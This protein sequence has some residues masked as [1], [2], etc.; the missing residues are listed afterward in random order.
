MQ[1][2]I[3]RY[4]CGSGGKQENWGSAGEFAFP[5]AEASGSQ[6]WGGIRKLRRLR[7]FVHPLCPPSDCGFVLFHGHVLLI[8][9][10]PQ[11]PHAAPNLHSRI[12]LLAG[13]FASSKPLAKSYASSA[14]NPRIR[15]QNR[16]HFTEV[17]PRKLP[18]GPQL[19]LRCM[20]FA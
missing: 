10:R 19:R 13:S 9:T 18:R 16:S 11:C 6:F 12:L 8:R 5:N 14:L 15:T 2:Q 3:H 17:T 1:D 7:M 4:L 20:Q